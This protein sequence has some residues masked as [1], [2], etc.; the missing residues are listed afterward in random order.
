MSEYGAPRG[1]FSL[2][3]LGNFPYLRLVLLCDFPYLSEYKAPGGTSERPALAEK[4]ALW[5]FHPEHRAPGRLPF[6]EHRASGRFSLS[7]YGVPRGVEDYLSRS[8]GL[9]IVF[10]SLSI[11]L[12]EDFPSLSIGLLGDF[13]PSLI[14]G[15]LGNTLSRSTGLLGDVPMLRR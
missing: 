11:G 2:G 9:L 14:I 15:S 4:G 1:I 10:P 7:D 12:L 13:F 5:T 3:L 6:P 8:T